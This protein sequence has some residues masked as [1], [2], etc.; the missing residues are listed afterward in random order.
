VH[1]A[2]HSSR[3]GDEEVYVMKADGSDVRQLTSNAAFADAV[4]AW[5]A[6]KHPRSR[7]RD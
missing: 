4:P 5:T 6:A 7:D 3:D 2:F 1:I